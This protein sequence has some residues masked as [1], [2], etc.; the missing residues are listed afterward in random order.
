MA[1]STITNSS[2]SLANRHTE[3]AGEE[4]RNTGQK[5]QDEQGELDE[6]TIPNHIEQVPQQEPH[7]SSNVPG[8]RHTPPETHHAD[9]PVDCVTEDEEA[10][11]AAALERQHLREAK[12]REMGDRQIADTETEDITKGWHDMHEDLRMLAAMGL[13]AKEGV[14]V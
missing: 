14:G 1:S 2:T 7:S 6:H 11:W 12:A 5:A 8:A 13:K 3:T 9:R 10:E 4:G